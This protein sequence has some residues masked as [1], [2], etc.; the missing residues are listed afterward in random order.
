MV[1]TT[2]QVK[3]NF[4]ICDKFANIYFLINPGNT[5]ML[6]A[7]SYQNILIFYFIETK[8]F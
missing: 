3:L 7:N 1:A 8:D 2:L 6:K 4:W 5:L